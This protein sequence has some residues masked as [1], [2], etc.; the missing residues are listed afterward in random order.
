MMSPKNLTLE[1]V[2]ACLERNKKESSSAAQWAAEELEKFLPIFKD[3]LRCKEEEDRLFAA[4]SADY[5]RRLRLAEQAN[6]EL[7]ASIEAAEEAGDF[8]TVDEIYARLDRMARLLPSKFDADA[9]RS[10]SKA[11]REAEGL[12]QKWMDSHKT[13]REFSFA[14]EEYKPGGDGNWMGGGYSKVD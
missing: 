5:E 14:F 2:V 4:K 9:Y 3:F 10:A 13:H 6:P 12:V 1:Q 8:E 11:A 7:L